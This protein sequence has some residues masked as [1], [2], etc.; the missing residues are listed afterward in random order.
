[1]ALEVDGPSHY[2]LPGGR[3]TNGSTLLKRRVLSMLGY[4]VMSVPYWE[5]NGLKDHVAKDAYLGRV[6][7]SH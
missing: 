6:L 7:T 2:L 1:M 3:E 4:K 5:W